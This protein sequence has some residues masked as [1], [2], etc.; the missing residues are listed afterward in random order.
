MADLEAHFETEHSDRFAKIPKKDSLEVEEIS[1]V[2]KS[3]K[4]MKTRK[5]SEASGR[6][7]EDKRRV[8]KLR[9]C[10]IR[11]CRHCLPGVGVMASAVIRRI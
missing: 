1:M 10:L 6:N 4:A 3:Y 8:E 2:G 11:T 5:G 9:K 7:K